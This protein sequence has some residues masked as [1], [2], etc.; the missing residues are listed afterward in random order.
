MTLLAGTGALTV[1]VL[2][3]RS[4]SSLLAPTSAL[5]GLGVL[6]ALA[7]IM[8]DLVWLAAVGTVVAGVGFGGSAL[9]TFGTFARI[10]RPHERSAVFASANII[11]YLGNSVPAVLGGIAVTTMGLRTATEIYALTIAAIVAAALLLRLN[12]PRASRRR[13]SE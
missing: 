10:A 8:A 12:Q 13:G 7:G 1:A 2:R 6:T 9:A 3:S 4:A 5:L 11:N